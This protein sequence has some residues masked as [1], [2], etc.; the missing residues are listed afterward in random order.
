MGA[1]DFQNLN[2][3]SWSQLK[4]MKDSGLATIGSHTYDMH[5]LEE[6]KPLFLTPAKY[7][8]FAEDLRKSKETIK[9]HLGIDPVYFAYPYGNTNDDVA[10]IVKDAGFHQAAILAPTLLQKITILII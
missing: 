9:N 10:K 3:A 4:E 5:R 6:D 2:M 8:A 7:S 1:T